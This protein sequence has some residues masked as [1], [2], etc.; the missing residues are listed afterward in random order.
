M[1]AI[2]RLHHAHQL[3][4]ITSRVVSTQNHRDRVSTGMGAN[5]ANVPLS[6]RKVLL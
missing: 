3:E 2:F 5:V 4:F 1:Q 6:R